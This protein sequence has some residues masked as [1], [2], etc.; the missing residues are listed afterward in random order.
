MPPSERGLFS[1]VVF[2][3]ARVV[4]GLLRVGWQLARRSMSTGGAQ[5]SV[6]EVGVGALRKAAVA[7]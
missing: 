5:L 1:P 2:L 6:C 3:G 4:A 7:E